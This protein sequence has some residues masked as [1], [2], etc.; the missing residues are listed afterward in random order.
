MSLYGLECCNR[1]DTIVSFRAGRVT[2]VQLGV[3]WRISVVE[4]G[5]ETKLLRPVVSPLI[6]LVRERA[7]LTPL[8]AAS[9]NH[10]RPVDIFE[11]GWTLA[12]DQS[13]AITDQP[14][15]DGAFA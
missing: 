10:L 1:R 5:S 15:H 6:S 3:N 2:N 12:T 4:G 9:I 14:E 11:T 8:T 13:L 7:R